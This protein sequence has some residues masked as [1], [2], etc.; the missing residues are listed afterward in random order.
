[1]VLVSESRQAP[2]P[3]DLFRTLGTALQTKSEY[4]KIRVVPLCPGLIGH[5]Q[6]QYSP[7]RLRNR[8]YLAHW[9]LISILEKS[10]EAQ[11]R[12]SGLSHLILFAPLQA[13]C[14]QDSTLD[15]KDWYRGERQPFWLEFED[16][17]LVF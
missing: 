2:K 10:S 9:A 14:S 4:I 6:L 16:I 17:P 13:Q 8:P 12:V 11:D 7:F 3:S 5:C 1:M 15:T